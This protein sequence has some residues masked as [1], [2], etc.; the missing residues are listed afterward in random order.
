MVNHTLVDSLVATARE[1]EVCLERQLAR[2][3]LSKDL[4]GRRRNDEHR[5]VGDERIER[6]A[7]RFGAHDH[8]GAPSVG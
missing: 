5:V 3:G 6:F 2:D 4:T 8:A 7:P 1:H